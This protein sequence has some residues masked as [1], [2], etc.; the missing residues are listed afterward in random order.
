MHCDFQLRTPERLTY[1]C[2]ADLRTANV[3]PLL[4]VRAQNYTPSQPV[5]LC[6]RRQ[7]LDHEI[8]YELVELVG[9]LE[10][11]PVVG[12]RER[13]LQPAL[14]IEFCAHP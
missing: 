7:S 1:T 2:G 8:S 9:L 10:V 5:V 11:Q 12:I 13:H 14:Q 4:S 6:D 3:W